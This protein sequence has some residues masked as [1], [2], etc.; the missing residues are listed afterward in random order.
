MCMMGI[1]N[2][3]KTTLYNKMSMRCLKQSVGYLSF[4]LVA[5]VLSLWPRAAEQRT[6]HK[7][8]IIVVIIIIIILIY[9]T[10]SRRV[11]GESRGK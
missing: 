8:N 10:A 5:I 1:Q 3:Q 7:V 6:P 9:H 4:M 11:R 2:T